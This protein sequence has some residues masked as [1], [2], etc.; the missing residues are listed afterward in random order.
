M[1]PKF[2]GFAVAEIGA[3]TSLDQVPI[4]SRCAAPVG[5]T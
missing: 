5:V 2:S 4:K 1:T 3:V